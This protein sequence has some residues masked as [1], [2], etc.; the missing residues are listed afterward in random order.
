MIAFTACSPASKE[1]EVKEVKSLE[2]GEN[3]FLNTLIENN[4]TG[5]QLQRESLVAVVSRACKEC[6][7]PR[8]VQRILDD[9]LESQNVVLINEELMP[10]DYPDHSDVIRLKP[11]ELEKAHIKLQGVSIIYLSKGEVEKIEPIPLNQRTY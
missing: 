10:T 6:V 8:H 11:G 1:S 4:C 5:K 9:K 3:D 7:N 2:V